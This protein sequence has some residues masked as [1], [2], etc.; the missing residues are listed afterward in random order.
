MVGTTT[1]GDG[2]RQVT[3]PLAATGPGA[4]V[5]FTVD[6]DDRM[7]SSTFGRSLVADSEING[8][9][10]TATLILAVRRAANGFWNVRLGR[11]RPHYRPAVLHVLIGVHPGGR[12]AGKLMAG[13]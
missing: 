10:V 1:V 7:K 3:L 8:A 9:R 2:D 6:V 12:A 13:F 11:R 5:E 4:A